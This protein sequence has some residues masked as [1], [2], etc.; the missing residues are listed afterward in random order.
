MVHIYEPEAEIIDT[1]ADFLQGVESNVYSQF[2]EDGLLAG[3]FDRIGTE[4]RWC[5]EVGASDGLIYSN[6][7]VLRDQQWSAVLIESSEKLVADLTH[8][9]AKETNSRVVGVEVGGDVTLDEL[10]EYADAPYDMDLG[11]IDIDGQDYWL[12]KDMTQFSPRVM[13]VEYAYKELSHFVP[14]RGGDGQAELAAIVDLG[15]SK[16]YRALVVTPCNVLFCREDV[17]KETDAGQ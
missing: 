1:W 14:D 6:T 9:A 16:G 5:F 4:N 17:M 12:W 15:V 10:L 2:G 8:L 7:K 3:L 13:L 11:V